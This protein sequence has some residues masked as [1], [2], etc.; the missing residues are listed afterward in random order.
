MF[1]S[2]FSFFCCKWDV[3]TVFIDTLMAINDHLTVNLTR[4]L[5]FEAVSDAC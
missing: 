2:L 3:V 4:L 1:K 5:D